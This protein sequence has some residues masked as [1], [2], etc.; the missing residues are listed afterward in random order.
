MVVGR[1]IS[2]DF[3]GLLEP[4]KNYI[5]DIFLILI[6]V[7]GIILILLRRKHKTIFFRILLG[8]WLLF[9]FFFTSL[10]IAQLSSYNCLYGN[11]EYITD[12]FRTVEDLA[13][14]TRIVYGCI[15]GFLN[16]TFFHVFNDFYFNFFR[17]IDTIFFSQ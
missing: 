4:F 14:Q 17:G 8:F 1:T 2:D 5:T 7:F 13:S 15:A 9:L 16:E 6:I 12:E 11:V 10:F 3:K